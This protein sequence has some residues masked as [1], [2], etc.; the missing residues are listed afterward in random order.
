M[1]QCLL[2]CI[3]NCPNNFELIFCLG[4]LNFEEPIF[5]YLLTFF[6]FFLDKLTFSIYNKYQSKK[7]AIFHFLMIIIE[8]DT[9]KEINELNIDDINKMNTYELNKTLSQIKTH[10]KKRIYFGVLLLLSGTVSV[11]EIILLIPE[12]VNVIPI[13]KIMTLSLG[14]TFLSSYEFAKESQIISDIMFNENDIQIEDEV[15]K[16]LDEKIHDAQKSIS[17][18]KSNLVSNDTKVDSKNNPTPSK[19]SYR[20]QSGTNGSSKVI[21]NVFKN[22]SKVKKRK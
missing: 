19:Y 2:L 11:S 14:A 6:Y 12:F 5:S 7:V 1:Y 18:R 22:L 20:Y 17:A 9:M 3:K 16:R 15:K 21:S 10:K 8:G 13:D 4:S